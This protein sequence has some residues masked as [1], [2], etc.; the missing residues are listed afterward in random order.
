[1]N[2]LYVPEIFSAYLFC[3]QFIQPLHLTHTY[4]SFI[5]TGRGKSNAQHQFPVRLH[6]IHLCKIKK[7]GWY[8]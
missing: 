6:P 4:D 5:P 3:D 7:N 1:M 8:W 2:E